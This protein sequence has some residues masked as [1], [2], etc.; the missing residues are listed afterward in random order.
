LEN[1]LKEILCF[2]SLLFGG[3]FFC[4]GRSFCNNLFS[5]RCNLFSN[6]R[7][8]RNNRFNSRCFS[9][10][11][12]RCFRNN[13][14]SNRRSFFCN[15]RSFCNNLF[16]S[17]RSCFNSDFRYSNSLYSFHRFF[18]GS[19]NGFFCF[20]D[21]RERWGSFYPCFCTAINSS[22]EFA[23][24]FSSLL[25][26]FCNS[27]FFLLN[28]SAEFLISLLLGDGTFG[29]THLKVLFVQNTFKT[30]NCMYG[31]GWLCANCQPII[32]TVAVDLDGCWNGKGI[33]GADL[34]DESTIA[35]CACVGGYD[36]VKRRFGAALALEAKFN[37][38]SCG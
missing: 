19:F 10:C 32:G 34:F 33:V 30:E 8:F 36:V 14:F 12:R 35:G 7:F 22:G 29:Y 26:A 24:A 3:S 16:N 9:F 17:R 15:R 6:R 2:V 1:I 23:L 18:C 31:I 13:L 37:C 25:A 38:H 27:S 4:F 28:P 20:F 11:N 5:S 21:Y